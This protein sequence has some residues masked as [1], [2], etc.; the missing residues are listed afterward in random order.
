LQLHSH[1]DYFSSLGLELLGWNSWRGS[2]RA[3][4]AASRPVATTAAHQ[5]EPAIAEP[6]GTQRVPN[7]TNVTDTAGQVGPI[8]K[9]SH[10]ENSNGHQHKRHIN[11]RAS[12]CERNL[13]SISAETW[14]ATKRYQPLR[15]D[16]FQ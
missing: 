9:H 5:S 2:S 1:I 8:E 11:I 16:V 15:N 12:V 13:G 4:H 6:L 3:S 10:D 7:E 14:T